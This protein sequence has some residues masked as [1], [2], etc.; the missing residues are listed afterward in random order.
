NFKCRKEHNSKAEDEVPI[1][2]RASTGVVKNEWRRDQPQSARRF[3]ALFPATQIQKLERAEG[4]HEDADYCGVDRH[5]LTNHITAHPRGQHDKG[6]Q[7][8]PDAIFPGVVNV[9]ET[10]ACH[11]VLQYWAHVGGEEVTHSETQ[12]RMG[13]Y[14]SI[15]W[16]IHLSKE[17]PDLYVIHKPSRKEAIFRAGVRRLSVLVLGHANCADASQRNR[18]TCQTGCTVC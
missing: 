8:H 17:T 4:Q 16:T 5:G 7:A 6:A 18:G 10:N 15:F 1:S 12:R 14:V 13:A 11:G 9:K 3:K 2:E